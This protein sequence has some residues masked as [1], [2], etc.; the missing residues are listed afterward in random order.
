MQ[1]KLGRNSFARITVTRKQL[2][3]YPIATCY[4]CGSIKYTPIKKQKFLYQY[5]FEVDGINT[6]PNPIK[7][8]F[9]SIEC[10]RNYNGDTK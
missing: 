10:C 1:I 9:C 5:L 3:T 2:F 6:K 7:G 4:W 8:F